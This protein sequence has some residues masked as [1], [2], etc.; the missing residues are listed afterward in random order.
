MKAGEFL[1]DLQEAVPRVTPGRVKALLL[2]IAIS[3]SC[4]A[5]LVVLFHVIPQVQLSDLKK[6]DYLSVFLA[7]L[8]PSLSVV[9][10]VHLFFPGQAVNV[11]V[12]S[13][14][15]SIFWVAVVAA[16][17]ST[18]GEVTGYYVGYSGQRLFK[19]ERFDRYKT[20]ERWMKRRGWLA[21]VTLAFL[22]LFI[23]DFVGIAAGALR[24]SLPKFLLFTY[25]GRLPRAVIEVYF[26]TWI[27]HNILSKLPHWVG[28][29]FSA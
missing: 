2:L 19:L 9:V 5:L 21:V 20:A 10:P 3:A 11:V 28:L 18:L 27:F 14:G 6:Y 22:P 15:N 7:N 1:A 16:A 17:G 26:Y 13:V 12:A 8:L 4:L 24:L 29:P 23:F 25:V